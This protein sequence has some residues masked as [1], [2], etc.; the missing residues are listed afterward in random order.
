MSVYHG[1]GGTAT[2]AGSIADIQSWSLEATADTADTTAMGDTF[3]SH[4]PG[5]TDF[6]ASIEAIAQTTVDTVGTY[7]G[8][9][10]ALVLTTSAS[11]HYFTCT[12]ICNGLTESVTIDDV[13][14]LAMTFEGNDADGLLY[15]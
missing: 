2:F 1:K 8:A 5:L 11:T 7:L 15:T 6:T 9:N 4:A 13:G 3:E 10:G 14:K 12:G